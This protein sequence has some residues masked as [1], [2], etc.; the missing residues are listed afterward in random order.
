MSR[1]FAVL[2][3]QKNRGQTSVRYTP[4]IKGED[5]VNSGAILTFQN[6]PKCAQNITE[7]LVENFV[8]FRLGSFAA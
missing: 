8:D 4:V 1:G 5:M 6:W 7:S 2:I 3:V